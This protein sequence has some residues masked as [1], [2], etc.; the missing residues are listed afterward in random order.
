MDA[1]EILPVGDSALLVTFGN[2]IGES[3][4]NQVNR[5]YQNLRT[6]PQRW[7][8]LIPAYASLT[9]V[10]DAEAIFRTHKRSPFAVVSEKV[11]EAAHQSV[12]VESSPRSITIPVCY[13]V[14]FNLDGSNVCKQRSIGPEELIHLHT[15]R[16]YRVYMLGFLPGFA[17]MG[18]V[19]S[20]LVV[21]R[22]TKPRAHVAPGSVAIA[23][24]QT[25]IYPLSSP[26]GW[27]IIGRTSLAMFDPRREN[28]SLL[29][30]G[31]LVHFVSI[32]IEDFNAYPV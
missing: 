26:G 14:E 2:A 31:D 27:N 17:Y 7:I 24:E 3:I 23:G 11:R 25:G 13:Q 18:S 15:S 21:P 20:R 4:N 19:D 6:Q 32:S 5:L 16:T 12:E 30:P 28:P 22:L 8:D 29:Q 9:I 1:F 10:Y